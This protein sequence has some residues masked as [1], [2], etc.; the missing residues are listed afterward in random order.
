[1]LVLERK[2]DYMPITQLRLFNKRGYDILTK[3]FFAYEYVLQ[4]DDAYRCKNIR[5]EFESFDIYYEN[6]KGNIYDHSCYYGYNFSND[7]VIKYNINIKNINFDAFINDDISTYTFEFLQKKEKEENNVIIEKGQKIQKWFSKID[8]IKSYDELLKKLKNFSRNY[9]FDNNKYIFFSLLIQKHKNSMA[10]LFF[11]YVCLH[12]VY[13]DC[14]GISFN[15]ILFYYGIDAAQTIIDNYCNAIWRENTRKEKKGEIG[16]MQRNLIL[17]QDSRT[18]CKKKGTFNFELQLFCVKYSFYA[19][20]EENA[21]MNIKKYMFSF[22]EFVNELNGDLRGCD[23]SKTSL[24]KEEILRYKID[25]RTKLP[26]IKSYSSYQVIKE[27]INENFSVTQRW[28]DEQ[29]IEVLNNRRTFEYF[30]DFVHYLQKNLANAD[31]LMCDNIVNI[32]GIKDLNLKGIK[33]RSDVAK[34]LGLNFNLIPQDKY[35]PIKFKT[36]EKFELNTMNDYMICR[37]K[38]ED[39]TDNISYVTDIHLLHR[40]VAWKCETY[41]DMLYITKLIAKEIGNDET[42]IQLIGGDITSDYGLY[43]TFIY[44]LNRYRLNKK[45]FLTLGNH[46]LWPF[47]GT[48]LNEIVEKYRKLITENNMMLVHNNLYYIEQF[49]IKEISTTELENID[50]NELR[51]KMRCAKLI[52]FG[53]IGFSGQNQEFNANQGIYKK[54]LDREQE[55]IESKKFDVLYKKVSRSLFDKNVIILTHMPMKDWSSHNDIIKGFVYI[56][57]HNHRNYYFDDGNMRIYADNQIGYNQKKVHMKY[58]FINM[59]YDWFSDYNDGIYVI[60]REDYINFYR[61]I[62]ERCTLNREF[63]KLYMLKR[64][65]TYLFLINSSGENLQILNGGSIKKV[66]KHSLQYFYDNL[67]KYAQSVKMFLSQFDEFQKNVSKEVKSIGGK[68]SIH[69][70]IVDID[71]YSHLYLNPFDGN[72]I[73]YFAYSMTDKYVY[74]NLPSLLKS[75]CPELYSNYEQKYINNKNNG[76]LA[77]VNNNFVITSKAIYVRDTEMYR[78]SRVLK[79]LQFTS[80][81]NIV[82]IWNDNVVED[83]SIENGRLIVS[84]I[85]NPKE[86]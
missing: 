18:I 65:G 63:K 4:N 12:K 74:E 72:V 40:C 42:R 39:Y 14:D 80:K 3:K 66:G 37:T 2:G 34:K 19:N 32:S 57:G 67:N 20:D 60:K 69:G 29:K 84:E 49:S 58:L 13:D 46:E 33:V 44:T 75:K 77:P 45:V 52:I 83:S 71:F 35:Q 50:D 16:K 15:D 73:P 31:L 56:S 59:N 36:T 8:E 43:E 6:L 61:G 79:G 47:F 25:D 7:E 27:Y 76:V 53:G 70:S 26:I 54:I 86:T 55:I 78:V 1:M 9:S 10:M 11:K 5:N 62:G 24:S 17:F 23:L 22:E 85:I 82:R 41:D 21:F 51:K 48:N 28:L 30:G 81:Y 38:D 64:D 68:G